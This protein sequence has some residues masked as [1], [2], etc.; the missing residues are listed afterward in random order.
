MKYSSCFVLLFLMSFTFTGQKIRWSETDLLQRSDFKASIRSNTNFKAST[1]CE[2]VVNSSLLRGNLSMVIR[3]QFLSSNS[4]MKPEATEMVL[5]HERQHFNIYEIC[6]RNI[7]KELSMTDTL[8]E[9]NYESVIK[10]IYRKNLSLCNKMN[11]K[12]DEETQ[13]SAEEKKQFEWEKKIAFMLTNLS[14]YKN[15]NFTVTVMKS[16]I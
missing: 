5:S 11:V 16:K 8:S 7:R 13:H 9:K 4:W 14:K 2:V 6:S 1:K 10:S 12:Y 15:E 3:T